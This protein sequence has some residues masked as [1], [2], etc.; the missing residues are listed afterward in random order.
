[1]LGLY[2]A[3]QIS[4]SNKKEIC[5]VL[6]RFIAALLFA[7]IVIIFCSSGITSLRKPL[8]EHLIEIRILSNSLQRLT[9][10]KNHEVLKRMKCQNLK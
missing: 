9:R 4:R 8:R 1:M 6:T 5:F 10:H 7:S 2:T 3:Y